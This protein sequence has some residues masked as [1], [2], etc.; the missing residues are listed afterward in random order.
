[1]RDPSQDDD[2]RLMIRAR[3]GDTDAFGAIVRRH[4]P[5]IERFLYRLCWDEEQ[6]ADGAQEVMLRL[7]LA[8]HNYD[9]I[10]SL[11]SYLYVIARNWWL[12]RVREAQCRPRTVALEEQLGNTGRRVLQDMLAAVEPT[13]T[14]VLRDYEVQRTRLAIGRLPE[15]QRLA[16]ILGHL[17]GLPYQQVAGVLGVP[18]GTVKS[19]VYHA[20][21]RLRTIL[22]ESEEAD[23]P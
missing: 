4:R 8:R 13:E 15:D 17:E 7:W 11:V 18:V 21:R 10:G 3:N 6:A 1:M 2:G 19:R 20:V 16:F 23:K 9:D 14:T 12:N 5:R 22:N